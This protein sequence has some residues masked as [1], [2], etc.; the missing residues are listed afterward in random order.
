M[1]GKDYYNILGVSRNASEREVKKAFRRLARKHQPD[2][3]ACAK[4]A[5][6]K[7]KDVRDAY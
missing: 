1:A 5:D 7:L 3:N 4:S 6:A 2:G